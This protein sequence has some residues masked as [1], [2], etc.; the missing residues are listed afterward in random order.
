VKRLGII[1]AGG[2]TAVMGLAAILLAWL[3]IVGGAGVPSS[4]RDPRAVAS[5][6]RG[7]NTLRP[8]FEAAA[9]HYQLGWRG[10]SVLAG[11]TS[12]ESDFGR[13]L[14]PST[15]GAIGWTQFMPATWKLYG[16]D[17]DGDGRR[18]PNTAS[19]AI[20]ASARYLRASGAPRD[21]YRALFAYNHADWYVDE[22][23]RR[24]Q[25][26]SGDRAQGLDAAACG[27]GVDL[28]IG[29]I[30]RI[31]G[32][33]H[34]AGVPGLPGELADDRIVGDID[35]LVR[36][37]HVAV[38][39]AYAPTGHA[40]DGEHPLGLAVDL[41]PGPGGSWDDV[42]AL[43]RWAEPVQGA[44]RPPFRWVGYDG[45]PGHGRGN[46]LHLSWEHAPAPRRR[47]PVAWVDVFDVSEAR[48]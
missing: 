16:V 29:G 27:V 24:A 5:L 25:R 28:G 47:P 30:R 43:A 40:P 44:P 12:V 2:A 9:Q 11:L 34:L 45:D 19:D 8:I 38:T 15:A 36:R 31:A 32:A 6:H 37:Y 23:L 35:Y 21:W 7:P 33:G 3:A 14:G 26:F 18:D 41:V 46:H 42:D 17:A 48:A 22:V 1:A 10:P 39:A 13:N 4:C 20:F